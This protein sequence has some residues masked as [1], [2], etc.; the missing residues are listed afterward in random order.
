MRNVPFKN[1]GGLKV[2]HVPDSSG[3][4][5]V[6]P[7]NSEHGDEVASIYS[8]PD[9]S[10][11][12]RSSS[13]GPLRRAS[14]SRSRAP[15]VAA[16]SVK[17]PGRVIPHRGHSDS[18]IREIT[19]RRSIVAADMSRDPPTKTRRILPPSEILDGLTKKHPRVELELQVSAPI[20]VGG[21]SIE[22]NVRI[23]IDEGESS[24][25]KKKIMSMTKLSVTLIGVEEVST[26]KR[27]I[28]LSLGTD[29]VDIDHPPPRDMVQNTKPLAPSEP[30]WYLTPSLTDMPF[31]ISLPLDIGPPPFQS[32]HAKIRYI[33]S[34]TLRIQELYKEWDVRNSH[35]TAV[36]TVYDRQCNPTLM[37][38]AAANGPLRSRES[39]SVFAQ[40][41][42]GY[43]H[44]CSSPLGRPRDHQSHCW[45]ASSG[46]GQRH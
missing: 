35:D 14:S 8:I 46:L 25:R 28:F 37:F 43:R 3:N 23:T 30:I 10:V 42:Q 13:R 32:R 12:Q 2:D 45:P 24:G 20:F 1:A 4:Q 6:P 27:H 31:L 11:P 36:L 22:G 16:K 44:L 34:V 26:T 39:T 15:S 38:Q 7:V 29:L 5:N 17:E 41:P 19:A 18:P 40:S 33:L 21:G 9:A